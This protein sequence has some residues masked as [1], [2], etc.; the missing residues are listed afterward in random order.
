[1]PRH[2]RYDRLI[3]VAGL[4]HPGKFMMWGLELMFIPWSF[5]SASAGHERQLRP[6]VS[7]GTGLI[8][9]V[10]TS[11]FTRLN[12][13]GYLPRLIGFGD[14]DWVKRLDQRWISDYFNQQRCSRLRERTRTTLEYP[15]TI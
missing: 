9:R 2:L 14:I 15:E 4:R 1:M 8:S 12:Y 6:R 5:M 13:C 10:P 7:G 3:H 11:L